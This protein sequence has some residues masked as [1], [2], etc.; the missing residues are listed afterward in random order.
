MSTKFFNNDDGNTL[1]ARLANIAGENGM[2]AKFQVFKAVAGYFRSS[3]WF[4]LREQL[5]GV[6]KIQILVGI[7]IDD[8]LRNRDRTELF[9]G[10]D[11][12]E[13]R[14]RYFEAFSNDVKEADYTE[15]IERGILQLCQDV[16][17]GR[18]ELRIHNSRNLHAK[19]YLC[20]PE[21]FGEHSEGRVIMGS[22]NLT[23]SGL[24]TRPDPKHRYELNVEIRDFDDVDF[25]RRE[26]ERLWDEGVSVTADDIAAARKATHL[27]QDPTPFELFMRV[28]IDL[29]GEQA[30]DD[31]D[32]DLP[33]GMMDL[34]YQRDAV[35]QGYQLLR[36]YNGFFLADVVGLG[37]TVVAAMIAQ[38]FIAENGKR[39]KVLVVHPP[40]VEQ[41]WKD[42]FESFKITKR[43]AKFVSNGS[44]HKV[45]DE[46][47]GAYWAPE[48]YDLVIVD[49]S[50][51]F[52]NTSTQAYAKLQ[53][54]CKTPRPTGGNL[55]GD[56]K[57]VVLV[58]ATALNNTPADLLNQ[59]RLFQDDGACTIDGVRDLAG[60]FAPLIRRYK[61]VMKAAR[62]TNQ[63]DK[64]AID[65]IYEKIRI[66]VL[67]K[68]LIRRTRQ[69]ILND[70]NYAAD[71]AA[72]GVVFPKVLPPHEILYQMDDA[73]A[74]LFSET[75]DRLENAVHY[76]RYRAIEFLTPE[77]KARYP[78]A[79]QV[80]DILT[81]VYKVFMVKRLESSFHAFKKSLATFLRV[82]QDM[83]R[84]FKED[85][86]LIIPDLDVTGYI[87]QGCTF[88]EIIRIAEERRGYRREDIS[89]PAS[90]FSPRLLELLREDERVL[91]GLVARWE[92]VDEDP[93]LDHFEEVLRGEIFEPARNPS[94]KLVVFSES[95]DTLEY[96][97]KQLKAR[98]GRSDILRVDAGNRQSLKATVRENFDANWADRKNDYNILLCSDALSEGVNLHRAN[99]VANYDSPW[100]ATRLMQRLGRV[101]RIGSAAGDIYNYLFYPSTQGNQI[102]G[103]YQYSVI[104]MQGFHSA[105]GEDA[106]IYSREELLR[107]FSLFDANPRD[108]MDDLLKYLH[109]LREFRS[110]HPEDYERIKALPVKC[111]AARNGR[112]GSTLVYLANNVRTAFYSVAPGGNPVQCAS[113]DALR[114][115]EASPEERAAPW[116]GKTAAAN[117]SAVQRV[118]RLFQDGGGEMPRTPAGSAPG[119]QQTKASLAFLR[120]CNRWAAPGGPL[121]PGAQRTIAALAELVRIGRY[122]PLKRDLFHLSRHYAR[123]PGA[124]AAEALADELETLLVTYPLVTDSRKPVPEEPLTLIVSETSG[125]ETP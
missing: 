104:R 108:D 21:A 102:I 44:L 38:R 47:E 28:L 31:F 55:P 50:H 99:I 56:Q 109:L 72:Q 101:N 24:G 78:N 26:F 89:Y 122:T 35:V 120:Q 40:A 13:T 25:C 107:E 105:L 118:L 115:L 86:V 41:N 80:A 15:E 3:G 52:R 45:L 84:M 6:K 8:I 75:S 12:A 58:T 87:E 123:K 110:R 63:V 37:K 66:G 19:F 14:R 18:V 116:T 43:Q 69:N 117:Y 92:K 53:R 106:Q 77:Y 124:D 100:N 54:I 60:F 90:A 59:I 42:T 36:K 125:A 73:L 2:G 1:F 97:E 5:G 57:K 121:D 39:T 70:A 82:T 10:A 16:V 71:I 34:K 68:I 7:D 30:E 22:S 114:W 67:E 46:H 76:A 98:L 79:K 94:G 85:S 51:G 81:K 61:A 4:K 29:Y 93:K 23:D 20:L 91:A 119:D 111:R 83:L 48:E 88:E 74:S 62:A 11:S 96:L 49:E 64:A 32:T 95:T 9:F 103:L 113:L 112:D 33:E 65:G 27:G 17:E